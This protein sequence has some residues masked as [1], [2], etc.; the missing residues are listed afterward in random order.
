M[1]TVCWVNQL[2]PGTMDGKG[3]ALIELPLSAAHST[4]DNNNNNSGQATEKR[5]SRAMPVERCSIIEG[6]AGHRSGGVRCGEE[7]QAPQRR[8]PKGA[9][10]HRSDVTRAS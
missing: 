6:R 4:Q 2:A 3:A 1:I 5:N 10:R 7:E 9:G 8:E